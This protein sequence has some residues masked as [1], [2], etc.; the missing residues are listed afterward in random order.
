VP[1]LTDLEDNMAISL[2]AARI[3]RE[4]GL[5]LPDATQLATAIYAKAKAFITN[6]H[7]LKQFKEIKIITLE[8]LN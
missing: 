8:Q 2:E 1:N 4:Y 5:R 6:D 3:R 7:R